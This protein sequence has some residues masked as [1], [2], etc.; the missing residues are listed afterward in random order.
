MAYP[1][2]RN[3]VL[4][5]S[6]ERRVLIVVIFYLVSFLLVCFQFMLQ[7]LVGFIVRLPDSF[8][9]GSNLGPFMILLPCYKYPVFF[10]FD[11]HYFISLS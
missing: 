4:F 5:F 3:P 6:L 10:H 1:A 8:S 11:P 7:L 2:K 9:P